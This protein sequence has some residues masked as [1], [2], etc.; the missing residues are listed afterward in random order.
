ME[1][2]IIPGKICP[3]Q[4]V[5]VYLDRAEVVRTAAFSTDRVGEH[6][7]RITDLSESLDPESIR[8]KGLG[9]SLILEVSHESVLVDDSKIANEPLKELKKKISDLEKQ[10]KSLSLQKQRLKDQQTHIQKYTESMLYGGPKGAAPLPVSEATGILSFNATEMAALDEKISAL[11][12]DN[13]RVGEEIIILRTDLVKSSTASKFGINNTY[14]VTVLLDVTQS[15]DIAVQLTYVVSNSTWRPSYDIRVSTTTNQMDVSYFADVTQST[16]E[17]WQD[18]DLF[19]STSNP[20]VGSS[21]PPLPMR[22]ADWSYKIAARRRNKDN[23]A[24]NINMKMAKK[25]ASNSDSDNNLQR[26][27]SFSLIDEED[28]DGGGLMRFQQ[29]AAISSAFPSAPPMPNTSDDSVL[30]SGVA[31]T[32]EAGATTFT[33]RRKVNIASDSKPH[34]VTVTS[35]TFSPQMVHYVSPNIDASA[36]L[37]AKVTNTSKFPLLASEKVSVFMDGNFISTTKMQPVSP[38]E[39][40]N[41]FLGV[42]PALKVEYRP[43]RTSF[44]VKGIFSSTEVK[45][46]EYCTVLR[47]T[48]QSVCRVIVAEILPRSSDENIVVELIDPE[49]AALSKLGDGKSVSVDQDMISALDSLRQDATAAATEAAA[50]PADFVTQNKVTNNIVWLKTIPAGDKVTVNFHYRLL[51]PKGKDVDIC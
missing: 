49:P 17:D 8:I 44:K 45:Q 33:I 6:E 31:G 26:R 1:S 37:Q 46:Y 11:D 32:G 14:T 2:R 42:D 3:V 10:Q 40:F 21:P 18:C 13:S 47:N 7:I 48:K 9:S 29:I 50:W 19:L 12:E 27:T 30:M 22:T 51:W 36:Y 16:G 4:S 23:R 43:C 34:K 25:T 28:G 39:S 35:E 38:G 24:H 41:I 5:T 20:S 15:G